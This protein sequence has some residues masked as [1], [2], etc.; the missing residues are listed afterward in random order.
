[1]DRTY[2]DL[3]IENKKWTTGPRNAEDS[4]NYFIKDLLIACYEPINYD[5]PFTIPQFDGELESFTKILER[6]K[7]KSDIKEINIGKSNPWYI[8]PICVVIM[9]VYRQVIISESHRRP[10]DLEILSDIA[11]RKIRDLLNLHSQVKKS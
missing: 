1:M 6:F 7:K 11:C 9:G 3:F 5:S 10:I 8:H 4:A 2:Y